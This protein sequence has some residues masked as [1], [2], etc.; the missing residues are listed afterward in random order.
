MTER[1]K[2][3]LVV[4]DSE[5]FLMFTSKLLRRLGHEN[6]ASV[7]NGADALKLLLTLMPDIILLD[8][9]MP[10]MDGIATLRHIKSD[11]RISNI[12]V[13]M[14]TGTSDSETYE[15]CKKLG[16]A[17]YLTKPVKVP[18]LNDILNKYITY[19][20]GKKRKFLRSTL[21]DKAIVSHK[22]ISEELHILCLSVGGVYVGKSNPYSVGTEVEVS[23]TLKDEKTINLKGTVI[24]VKAL[25][26]AIY[27]GFP[28]MAIKFKNLTSDVSET[29]RAYV[30]EL[31]IEEIID[32]QV[33]HIIL[34]DSSE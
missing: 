32:E 16:C 15:E 26:K 11:K 12:P 14:T 7:K 21:Q 34:K 17:G 28:G 27:G 31:L 20:G 33:D 8:I 19:P 29:L 6:I 30:E 9:A 1:T 23:L 13:I 25:N 5:T 2:T 4:D 3:I 10:Q 24:Y 22:A 18:E